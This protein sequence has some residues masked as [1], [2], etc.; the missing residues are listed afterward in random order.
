MNADISVSRKGSDQSAKLSVSITPVLDNEG[1]LNKILMY[2]SDIPQV[3]ISSTFP[4]HQF[5]FLS[6]LRQVK[7]S[8]GS[9]Q[10][11]HYR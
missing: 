6:A 8:L 9:F 3:I 5:Y 1:Q 2:G 11:I 7:I 10:G 4:H